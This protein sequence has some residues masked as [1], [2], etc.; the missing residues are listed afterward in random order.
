MRKVAAA[1]TP[2]LVLVTDAPLPPAAYES[3]PDSKDNKS[4]HYLDFDSSNKMLNILS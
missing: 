1:L 2:L 3:L 4:S